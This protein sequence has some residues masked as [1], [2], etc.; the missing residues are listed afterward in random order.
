MVLEA[1]F[2]GIAVEVVAEPEEE[3]G[4]DVVVLATVNRAI[5]FPMEDTPMPFG[6]L[7]PKRKNHGF[8]NFVTKEMIPNEEEHP[9]C[10]PCRQELRQF[11]KY[12]TSRKNQETNQEGLEL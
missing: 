4:E 11:Q 8:T 2:K 6:V 7:S 1:D 12:I 5:Y 3:A 9:P 10:R